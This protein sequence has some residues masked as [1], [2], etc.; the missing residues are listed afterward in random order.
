MSMS[1][2]PMANRLLALVLT[3]VLFCSCTLENFEPIPFEYPD[4]KFWAH[5]VNSIEQIDKIAP[6][7]DGMEIDIVYSEWQ[8]ELFV[9]HDLWDT[10]LKLT[11]QMWL[12][13]IAEPASHHFWLDLKNLTTDNAPKV[14]SKIIDAM[15]KYEIEGKVMVESKDIYAL[16]TIQKSGIPIILWVESTYYTGDSERKWETLT[17]SKIERLHP[18]AISSDYHAFP[19]L[20]ETFPD[21]NIHIWDTP[22]EYNDTNVAHT[23]KIA[24]HPSVKVVLIDYPKPL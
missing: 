23:L 13:T 3:A 19:L 5:S 7:F 12:D 24:D 2:S 22:R 9:G 11:F 17:K 18:N 1:L 15:K 21:E 10:C 4:S 8:D 6:L 14:A 20:P 16:Q